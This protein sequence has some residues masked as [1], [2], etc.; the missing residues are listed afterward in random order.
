MGRIDDTFISHA[1]DVLAETKSGLSGS[2]I[3]KYCNSYAIDFNVRM[4]VSSP[5]FGK[6]GSVIPNKRTALYK[7]LQAFSD[8]QQFTIIK[9]LCDLDFFKDNEAVQKLKVMLYTR[10]GDLA[11]E[12]LAS[13]ELVVKTKHWLSKYP[14]ALEQYSSALTKYEG[15]IFERNTLDDMR[16]S[17]E[18]LVK[19]LLSNE[20]SLENQIAGLGQMLKEHSASVELRN[21]VIQIIKYY[22]DFQNNHVKHNDKV[23]EDEIEYVI[24]LTSVVMKYLIKMNGKIK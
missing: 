14:A 5:D 17:F 3:V 13:T 16:L 6:F 22:T 15:G 12:K 7:N 19:E 10:Y 9:E 4:P 1:S 20:K 23:N 8:V 18:L 24:E 21:M 11:E 2:Q